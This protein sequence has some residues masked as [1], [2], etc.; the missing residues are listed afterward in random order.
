MVQIHDAK[1]PF[2]LPLYKV[3]ES[4]NIFFCKGNIITGPNIFFLLFTYIIIII[5]VLPIYIITYFQI[6][7]SFCLTVA[8]VSLTIFFILVLFFLTTTAFCDP[9]IIPK[10]NYVDLSLPKGRTAFTTVKINGTIIK[11]YWCVNCNHFKEPRSKHCYTC[12]NCVTKFDHH[13]VWIGNCVGNRNYRRF[14][15]F[16]LNLSILSTIICFI[17]IGI[18]IQLCIKENGSLSFQPILYTIG[19]YPH[20]ILYIIY[21]FPSSLLLINLF[22]YHLQMVL[23]NKTTYEDIQGLYSGNNPFDE[24]KFIN[25]KKFLFTPVD[26]MQVEWKDIVKNITHLPILICQKYINIFKTP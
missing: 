9:G 23:Q 12:N 4:N 22:V 7:S 5:S 8:L 6:D 2:L 21:A 17:F 26:K 19:E 3:Y 14:F 25:L 15:F 24:G 10:R 18:F 1:S 13:C 16:I 11:Q 20:I